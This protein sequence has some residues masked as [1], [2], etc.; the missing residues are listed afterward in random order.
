MCI[1]YIQVTISSPSWATPYEKALGE[2]ESEVAEALAH[3]HAPSI[4]NA[5]LEMREV[6]NE[7]FT[8]L[9]S[10]L[11]AECV[12]LCRRGASRFRSIEV[13]K[14]SSF[15][16]EDFIE[17]LNSKSPLLLQFLTTVASRVDKRYQQTSPAERY[18]GIVTA[19]AVL[20]KQRNRE[21]C[22]IPS[23]VSLLMYACHCEKQVLGT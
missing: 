11:N 16:W 21:M 3:G 13:D 23:V 7:I 14:I 4:A 5:I 19:A 9:L 18:P 2:A 8:L 1:N 6:R 20:L 22:A 15:K 10:L 17:E 12:E